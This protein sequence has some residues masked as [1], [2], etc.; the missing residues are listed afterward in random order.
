MISIIGVTT[1][2]KA[3]TRIAPSSLKS[4]RT[5]SSAFTSDR[6]SPLQ[7]R[8]ANLTFARG[9]KKKA[10]DEPVKVDKKKSERKQKKAE[11][12]VD[13]NTLFKPIAIMPNPDDINVGLEIAG[14]INRQELL[15]RLN[16]FYQSKTTKALAKDH[17]LDDYLCHQAYISFR[18]YCMD[19]EHLPSELYITFSDILQD[20]RHEDDIFPYFLTHARRV[21]PHLECLDELKLISDLTDPPNW[22]PDARAMNRKIIFHAGPTNSGKTYHALERFMSAKSGVY[23]GPLKLL[24]KSNFHN[25]LTPTLSVD[26]QPL[27]SLRSAMTEEPLVIL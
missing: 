16:R 21:F 15:K 23:C 6:N 11:K 27:K 8:T 14:K 4:V 1:K 20:A 26:F 22:Y 17:G 18:K 24:G 19:V 25:F 7:T 9:R 12:P 13:V 5:V 2:A 10:K 3:I